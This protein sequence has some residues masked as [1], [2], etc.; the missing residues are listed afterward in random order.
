MV[1]RLQSWQMYRRFCKEV[2]KAAREWH[3][4][5]GFDLCHHVTIATWRIPSPLWYLPIP[6]IWGP[7]GGAGTIPRPFRSVLSTQAKIFELARDISTAFT[8]HNPAFKKCLAETTV[9]IAASQETFELLQPLRGTK[10][11]YHLPVLSVTDA[12]C[13]ALQR[14]TNLDDQY[15]PLQLF[16]GGNI[17]GRKGV[18]FALKA[19]ASVKQQGID[20]RYTIAGGGPDIEHLRNLAAELDLVQEVIFHPGYKGD[21]YRKILHETD[22]YLLPSFRETLG[23]TL[24]EAILAGCYPIVADISA[25]GE[26]VRLTGGGLIQLTEPESFVNDLAREI[27]DCARKRGSLFTSM[28]EGREILKSHLSSNRYED[29]IEKIYA[30]ALSLRG[31]V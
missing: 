2:L 5:I 22:I 7:I 11:L 13:R 26:I 15:R 31:H 18:S 28:Q 1:A 21:D 27:I 17:E 3:E 30:L 19:L 9:I 12:S 8:L 10:A 29:E 24:V 6:F 16:A 20:F 14:P 4:E 25:Q 23:M